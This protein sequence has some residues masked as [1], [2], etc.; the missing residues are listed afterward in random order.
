MIYYYRI[1][2]IYWALNLRH[3]PGVNKSNI[4]FGSKINL[5][6]PAPSGD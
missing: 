6:G 4:V 3:F 1:Y 5:V 2:P